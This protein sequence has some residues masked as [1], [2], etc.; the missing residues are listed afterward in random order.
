[1]E[2][3]AVDDSATHFANAVTATMDTGTTKTAYTWYE[4]DLPGGGGL[5]A[6][7]VVASVSDPTALFLLSP[8]TG[9][10]AL[11]L[12]AATT[13]GTL[14]LATPAEYSAL[15]FLTSS[16]LG[17]AASPVLALTVNF[18]DGTAPLAGLGVSSPDWFNNAILR[19]PLNRPSDAR[20]RGDWY[21]MPGSSGKPGTGARV[22]W[23]PQPRAAERR[24][25]LRS[26]RRPRTRPF[27]ERAG[28]LP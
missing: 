17:S 9:S 5:P 1:V 19:F 23:S 7:G 6:A 2:A 12:D 13:S 21:L 27:R 18:A 15:S 4:H 25:R 3:G 11:L 8:Y 26:S 20:G 10:N 24:H 22:R 28:S 14:T 16:S